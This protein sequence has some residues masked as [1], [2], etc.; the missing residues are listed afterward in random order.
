MR[1]VYFMCHT[2]IATFW[3]TFPTSPIRRQKS[4]SNTRNKLSFSF[5]SLSFSFSVCVLFSC[6]VTL[7]MPLSRFVCGVSLKI[8]ESC[9]RKL[10]RHSP[11]VSF[12]GFD[13]IFF[14]LA[15]CHS[16]FSLP[17]PATP[18]PPPIFVSVSFSFVVSLWHITHMNTSMSQFCGL[19]VM[20]I[21]GKIHFVHDFS[22]I[23]EKIWFS[24]VCV[25]LVFMSQKSSY[26]RMTL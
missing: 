11:F 16:R 22:H 13:S 10:H 9:Q 1:S 14:P 7:N 26:G 17:S 19:F 4:D 20:H 24:C 12:V 5:L 6:S 8:D 21:Y 23:G 3:S 18:L 15:V 2:Q 25:C